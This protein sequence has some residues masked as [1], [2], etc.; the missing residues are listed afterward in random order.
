MLEHPDRYEWVCVEADGFGFLDDVVALRQDGTIEAKQVKFSAYPEEAD[1]PYDWDDL[2]AK[3]KGKNGSELPSLIGKW[4]PTLLNLLTKYG[5]VEAAL[6]TNRRAAQDLD[7][8]I[9]EGTGLV[10][11][12]CLPD[13]VT[14]ELTQQLGDDEDVT[15]FLRVF[16]FMMDHPA[17]NTLEE[18]FRHR[19]ELIG[20]THEGWLNLKDTLRKWVREKE[21]PAP[22]GHVRLADVQRAALWHRLEALPQGFSI[23]TDYVLPSE[24][25]H[26]NIVERL[27]NQKGACLVI[28]GTPGI[29][30]STYL[31]YLHEELRTHGRAVVRHH[32]FLSLGDATVG[33]FEHTRVIESLMADL[34]GEAMKALVEF[35]GRNTAPHE[36]PKWLEACSAYYSKMDFPLV[37]IVDGLDHVSRDRGDITELTRLF[38]HLFPCRPGIC[39]VIGTQPLTVANLPKRLL[40][41]APRECWIALPPLDRQAVLK[42]TRM[43]TDRLDFRRNTSPDDIEDELREIASAFFA[44]SQGQPLLLRYGLNALIE[45]GQPVNAR[46]IGDRMPAA[47]GNITEYYRS[48]WNGLGSDGR[49]I[50]CMIATSGFEW[51]PN[52]ISACCARHG[53]DLLEAERSWQQVIHMMCR[54]PLGWRPFHSSLAVFVTEKEEYREFLQQ[55]RLAVASW[56]AE[57]APEYWR[58]AYEWAIW[59]DMGDYQPLLSG[60][61]REWIVESLAKGYPQG[62]VCELLERA[63]RQA[64]ISGDMRAFAHKALLFEYVN[65]E[66]NLTNWDM[67]DERTFAQ[68]RCG[69]VEH[70]PYVLLNRQAELNDRQLSKLAGALSSLGAE[71]RVSA[72]F[73]ELVDRVNTRARTARSNDWISEVTPIVWTESLIEKFGASRIAE[74]I[75][76]NRK[77]IDSPHFSRVYAEVLRAQKR[78]DLLRQ[79]CDADLTDAERGP[80]LKQGFLVALEEGADWQDVARRHSASLFAAIYARVTN[81]PEFAAGSFSLPDLSVLSIRSHEFF[82]REFVVANWLD[83]CFYTI[84]AH[85]LWDRGQAVED[86]L[87]EVG[88]HSWARAFVQRLA[89][90]AKELAHAILAHRGHT[91]AD[92]YMMFREL[93]QPPFNGKEG[94]YEFWRVTRRVLVEVGLDS[95]LL[96]AGTSSP[97]IGR[98]VLDYAFA[99]PH[100]YWSDWIRKYVERRRLWLSANA[101]EW[102]AGKY[103]ENHKANIEEIAR[104][105]VSDASV[106]A[107]LMAMHGK[108]EQTLGFLRRA[109]DLTLTYGHHKDILLYDYVEVIKRIA[110]EQPERGRQELV[111]VISAILHLHEFTDGDETRHVTT[112]LFDLLVTL[113]PEWLPPIYCYMCRKED[114]YDAA[115]AFRGILKSLPFASD[116]EIAIGSTCLD[117]DGINSISIMASQGCAGAQQ[118]LDSVRQLLGS[119]RFANK[120]KEDSDQS[121]G[122]SF[123]EDSVPP[124]ILNYPPESILDYWRAVRAS[125]YGRGAKELKAWVTHWELKTTLP[126]VRNALVSLYEVE[127]FAEVASIVHDMTVRLEGRAQAWTWLVKAHQEVHGWSEHW[128]SKDEALSKWEIV[129]RHYP[130]RW[131]DFVV[132]TMAPGRWSWDGIGIHGRFPRLIEYLLMLDKKSEAISVLQGVREAIETLVHPFGL[133]A[134]DW[135]DEGKSREDQLL[136]ILL[137]RLTW[138][139]G[140]VQER[141]C[142]VL[143]DLLICGDNAG[144]VSSALAD[145]IQKQ[146]LESV[147]CYGLLPFI[148]A[149]QLNADVAVPAAD[150]LRGICSRPSL[151]YEI[152]LEQLYPNSGRALSVGIGH[153]GNAPHDFQPCAKFTEHFDR[154]L[155]TMYRDYAVMIGRRFGIPFQRQWAYEAEHT[156][157]GLKG[158]CVD[159][160]FWGRPDSEHFVAFDT[161]LSEGLRSGYLRALSWLAEQGEEQYEWSMQQAL[162]TLPLD[163]GLWQVEP[164]D[165]PAWWPVL[166]TPEKTDV[167]TIPAEVLAV[168]DDL[169]MRQRASDWV[170]GMAS[171]RVAEG[172]A[173]YDLEVFGIFQECLGPNTPEAEAV[174]KSRPWCNEGIMLHP[175]SPRFGGTPIEP[176]V[177]IGTVRLGD[178]VIRPCVQ[179]AH[180]YVVPRWQW[181]RFIRGTWAPLPALACNG[182]YNVGCENNR[183]SFHDEDGEFS[184]WQDWTAGMSEMQDGH[185]TPR[186]GQFLMLKQSLVKRY[187]A[188]N[189]QTFCWICKI[190]GFHREH[191]RGEN[192]EFSIYRVLGSS[193][194]VL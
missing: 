80:F 89:V 189:K 65:D 76:K 82:E 177:E 121:S 185:M 18:G 132:E 28:S 123:T 179:A 72:I 131:L 67:Q 78:G 126:A 14:R 37:I 24:P 81:V 8:C 69:F 9:E 64:L 66:F 83:G 107:T 127:D 137:A 5:K 17:L 194:L 178:W 99:S 86:W 25:L 111:P 59:A 108:Q 2:T 191:G 147:A 12:E 88:A 173:I 98:D 84:L 118:V 100:C 15:R 73:H 193:R 122:T 97:S 34:R 22:D 50:L 188:E 192:K 79:L 26:M 10:R 115:E 139:S 16:R 150:H 68:L 71:P 90:A 149:R 146:V 4:G 51:P 3:R 144:R 181:W 186:T 164:Q 125:S 153:A 52:G 142:S 141:A 19:F 56:L 47:T 165:L 140:M 113:A 13:D 161:P 166:N 55:V 62:Q 184:Y 58:W 75:R 151:L 36:F 35:S 63:A 44:F 21:S 70:L 46:S 23:P 29:G 32:Y 61:T 102:I 30:K 1:D 171:G 112:Q 162:R 85:Y 130:E 74:R 48:L 45:T 93:P 60:T 40:D 77:Q 154:A 143:A 133:G 187:E 31:S 7:R 155:P 27:S 148:R 87:T 167:D 180:L 42:W 136:G 170:L 91:I 128:T 6:V 135:Q 53:I 43:N 96:A 95:I 190:S 103:G 104:D 101:L 134:P 57:D 172:G 94:A 116:M 129:E 119:N 20:G 117:Q 163:L 175:I 183:V 157:D 38:E 92:F 159:I 41:V 39:L 106:V 124:K 160:H 174:W 11:P 145:W 169:W 49:F 138:P 54:T 109:V 120:E 158:A 114:Y 168:L 33:R 182:H 105:G 176:S 152:L 156:G 110:K